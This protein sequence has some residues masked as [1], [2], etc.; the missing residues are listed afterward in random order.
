MDLDVQLQ[1]VSKMFEHTYTKAV[2]VTLNLKAKLY[3]NL[4]IDHVELLW[5]NYRL[6]D[7]GDGGYY[8]QSPAEDADTI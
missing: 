2:K 1:A 5:V 4:T 7:S 6:C 8:D 3:A